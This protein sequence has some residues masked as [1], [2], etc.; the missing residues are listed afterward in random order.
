MQGGT[1]SLCRNG[2]LIH[3]VF[4]DKDAGADL[5]LLHK[6]QDILA[7]TVSGKKFVNLISAVFSWFS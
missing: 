4:C 3:H 5:V 6:D 7:P 2:F 1:G